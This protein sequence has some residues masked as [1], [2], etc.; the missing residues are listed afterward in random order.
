VRSNTLGSRASWLKVSLFNIDPASGRL[1]A[2]AESLSIPK[3][4]TIAFYARKQQ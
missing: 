1:S 3:P 2:T 4:V